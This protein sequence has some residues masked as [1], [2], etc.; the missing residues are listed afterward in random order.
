MGSRGR[1]SKAELMVSADIM[2]GSRPDAPY[3]LN[4]QEA[5]EWRA[6]VATMQPDYFA[7]THYPLLVQLCRHIVASNRIAQLVD[8]ECRKR[9]LNRGEL[10]DWLNMQTKESEAII[11]LCR[12]LRLSPQAVYHNSGN[13]AKPSMLI[14]VPWAGSEDVD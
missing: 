1:K 7:R 11:R 4:D 13:K 6:I 12:Q 14:D 9:K 2:V 3:N 8:S 10:Q 5:D